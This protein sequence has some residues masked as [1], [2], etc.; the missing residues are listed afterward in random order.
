MTYSLQY[1]IYEVVAWNFWLRTCSS[2]EPSM[3]CLEFTARLS[4]AF[5]WFL[6]SKR[7][8]TNSQVFQKGNSQNK[9][10]LIPKPGF[11]RKESTCSLWSGP[12]ELIVYR[13]E[14]AVWSLQ[15]LALTVMLRVYY[16]LLVC[17]RT[18]CLDPIADSSESRAHSLEL[19]AYSLCPWI[20]E[21]GFLDQA[22]LNFLNSLNFLNT[23]EF[24]ES[25][26]VIKID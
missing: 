13:L 1:L 19:I 2:L 6:M 26:F 9:N 4:H 23:F 21:L 20:L 11:L 3:Y 25:P 17:P 14:L 15:T 16:N 7:D 18:Y 8:S 12:Y 10:S 5:L 22:I 24:F